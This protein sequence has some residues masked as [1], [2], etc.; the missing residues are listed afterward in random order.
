M[1]LVR[2]GGEGWGKPSDF[3]LVN[4]LSLGGEG[5]GGDV[6]AG[7]IGARKY[8]CQ[9]ALSFGLVSVFCEVD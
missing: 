4:V 7:G 3:D 5:G 2:L 6:V 9:G 8:T 1:E